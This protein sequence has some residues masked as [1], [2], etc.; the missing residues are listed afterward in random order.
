MNEYSI[1]SV[2]SSLCYK[3]FRHTNNIVRKV[4][5]YI[6]IELKSAHST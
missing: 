6:T 1:G 3:I 5:A 4:I 2:S